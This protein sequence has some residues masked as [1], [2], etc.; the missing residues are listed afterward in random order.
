MLISWTCENVHLM[1]LVCRSSNWLFSKAIG[2]ISFDKISIEVFLVK[3]VLCLNMICCLFEHFFIRHIDGKY[4]SATAPLVHFSHED[5][6]FSFDEDLPNEKTSFF[7]F[8]L[9]P[10]WPKNV[11]DKF[12][13]RIYNSKFS[14]TTSFTFCINNSNK[15]SFYEEDCPIKKSIFS[16]HRNLDK[17]KHGFILTS[18]DLLILWILLKNSSLEFFH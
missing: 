14:I 12:R 15:S 1:L 13:S 8:Q 17:A 10:G 7:S 2:L 18:L 5:D 6:S 9:N 11:I 4:R 3:M 16:L